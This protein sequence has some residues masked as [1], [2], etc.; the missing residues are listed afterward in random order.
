MLLRLRDQTVQNAT[1]LADLV[2]DQDQDCVQDVSEYLKDIKGRN[3]L[4]ILEGLDELPKHFLTQSSVFTRLPLRQT[5][6]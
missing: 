6:P 4:I 1:S 3:I 5:T 2:F